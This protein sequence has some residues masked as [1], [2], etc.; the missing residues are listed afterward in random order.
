MKVVFLAV[1]DFANVG[2][3]YMQALESVGIY[4]QGFK[5]FRHHFRYPEGLSIILV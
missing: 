3:A 2:W 4:N 1:N 5:T